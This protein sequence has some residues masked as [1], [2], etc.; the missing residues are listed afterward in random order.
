MI[1]SPTPSAATRPEARPGL[2]GLPIAELEAWLTERGEPAWRARQ[3]ST[4]LWQGAQEAG[5]IAVLPRELRAALDDAFR[6]DTIAAT[7]L[8]IADGD[9]T[10][11]GLHH[12]ADGALVE[13][14]LMHY[15]ARTG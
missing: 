6:F 7:E 10:E 1:A 5:Q 13:S 2:S 11:K 12:L 9:R 8:R 15:P 3:V 4:A 14:V